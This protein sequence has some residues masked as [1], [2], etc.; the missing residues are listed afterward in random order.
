MVDMGVPSYL[1][2][3]SVIA[4]LAQRLVRVV[5]AKCKQPY[6]P[7]DAVLESAGIS[8]EQAEKANFCRGKGCGN[9][10]RG[11]FRGRIGIYE[12][13]LMRTRIREMAFQGASTQEI[14]KVAIAQGMHT[15]YQ[16]GM[17][18]AMKG[19]TTIEEVFRVAKRTTDD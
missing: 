4:I 16:D 13:L 8:R 14:R 7:S 1:V 12:L 6:T 19:I 17:A 15:L 5:C 11:G 9:C 3:S 10:Q 18:K 2:A